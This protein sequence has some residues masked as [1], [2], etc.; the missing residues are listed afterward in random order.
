MVKN[1]VLRFLAA[2]TER[3]TGLVIHFMIDKV[4]TYISYYPDPVY[5]EWRSICTESSQNITASCKKHL[6]SECIVL[7]V[8]VRLLLIIPF[9]IIGTAR[10][11]KKFN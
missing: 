6:N 10:K 11:L 9:D 4:K 8:P 3:E 1:S 2:N 5:S 7:T